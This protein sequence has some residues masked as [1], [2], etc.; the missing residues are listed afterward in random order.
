MTAA[1]VE[2]VNG[3]LPSTAWYRVAPSAHRSAGR[4]DLAVFQL[5]RRQVGHGA[6]ARPCAGQ[7]GGGVEDAGDAE[8]GDDGVVP[9]RAGQQ[10]VVRL[11]V[12]VHDAGRV[13][14]RERAG[15][16]LADPRRPLPG[17]PAEP[18]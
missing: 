14:V 7:L 18:R 15:D 1:M 13:R 3:G 9:R 16:L 17:Q 11:Q 2:P 6:D 10:D 4:A 12:A 8:V 5:L